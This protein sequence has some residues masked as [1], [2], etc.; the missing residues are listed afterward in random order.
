MDFCLHVVE[1]SVSLTL[2]Y[3]LCF[4]SEVERVDWVRT[5]NETMVGREW[6]CTY[7]DKNTLTREYSYVLF[8]RE[9]WPKSGVVRTYLPD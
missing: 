9:G 3:A 6:L 5:K 7:V 1:F 8:G 2:H 4:H